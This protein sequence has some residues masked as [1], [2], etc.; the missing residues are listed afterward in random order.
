LQYGT[1]QLYLM[2]FPFVSEKDLDDYLNL[3]ITRF[4]RAQLQLRRQ[5]FLKTGAGFSRRKA[6]ADSSRL[7]FFYEF[8]GTPEG[9]PFQ[10]SVFVANARRQALKS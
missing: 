2:N 4:E 1:D 6:A 9:V 8:G 10:R 3:Q 7:P 5:G